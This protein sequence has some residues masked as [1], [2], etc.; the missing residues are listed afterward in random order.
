ME[1]PERR[2][3]LRFSETFFKG[4][5]VSPVNFKESKENTQSQALP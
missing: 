3:W 1:S 4:A 5:Y 2:L